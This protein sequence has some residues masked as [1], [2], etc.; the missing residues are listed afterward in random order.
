[1][2]RLW[3]GVRRSIAPDKPFGETVLNERKAGVYGRNRTEPTK[4]QLKAI[5][6]ILE[7]KSIT[8]GVKRAGIAKSLFTNG[9]RPL[10]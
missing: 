8:D 3:A 10:I 5:A 7:A 4:N 1:M 2:E 9:L 6:P